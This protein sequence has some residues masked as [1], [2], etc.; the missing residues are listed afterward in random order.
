[1]MS[2]KNHTNLHTDK[3]AK[4]WLFKSVCGLICVFATSLVH[5]QAQ[6]NTSS[7]ASLTKPNSTGGSLC[8]R[9]PH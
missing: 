8:A 9:R 3:D 4:R 7:N 2:T 5:V 6:T 1:M